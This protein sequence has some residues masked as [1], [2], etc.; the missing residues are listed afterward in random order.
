MASEAL[1]TGAHA[2]AHEE[3]H[4]EPPARVE[5]GVI[6]SELIATTEA[7]GSGVRTWAWVLGTV[8]M[9]GIVVGFAKLL[10]EWGDQ[11][12]WGYLAAMVAFLFTAF[13]VPRW[14]R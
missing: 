14:W 9:V 2:A 3:G 6:T 11:D 1:H 5:A 10:M 8:A 4:H 13:G 12:E 7:N